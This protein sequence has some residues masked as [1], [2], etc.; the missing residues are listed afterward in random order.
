MTILFI[1][2]RSRGKTQLD[3]DALLSANRQTSTNT[4]SYSSC[5][6]WKADHYKRPALSVSKVVYHRALQCCSSCCSSSS[7]YQLVYCHILCVTF[8]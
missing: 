4:L 6:P 8:R 7:G 1:H 3:Q 2:M 5:S